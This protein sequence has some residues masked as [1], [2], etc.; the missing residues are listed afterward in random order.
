MH[1]PF[2]HRRIRRQYFVPA[3]TS[4]ENS[5]V[6]R[7]IV[8]APPVE[9]QFRIP[10]RTQGEIGVPPG[11]LVII[12]KIF[13]SEESIERIF[14]TVRAPCI[15]GR[16]DVMKF[17]ADRKG[18]YTAHNVMEAR[19]FLPSPDIR[20]RQPELPAESPCPPLRGKAI[21]PAAF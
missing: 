3:K 4:I 18:R 2:G 8:I 19:I 15:I 21:S 16:G 7:F 11:E 14:Q 10:K 5:L 9:A 17:P 12:S 1:L 13:A 20:K 6:Y